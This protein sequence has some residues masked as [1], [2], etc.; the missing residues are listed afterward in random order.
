[1]LAVFDKS[2]GTI[3]ESL[4]YTSFV[5]PT[6]TT[7]YRLDDEALRIEPFCAHVIAG[8][9]EVVTLGKSSVIVS[10][11]ANCVS[12]EIEV[13]SYRDSAVLEPFAMNYAVVQMDDF[14]NGFGRAR[15]LFCGHFT[16][17]DQIAI[18]SP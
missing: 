14:S 9:V 8:T 2:R 5:P 10:K 6:F 16:V 13:V 12:I 7:V 11:S 1:M 17:V 18:T 15:R 3:L 4:W